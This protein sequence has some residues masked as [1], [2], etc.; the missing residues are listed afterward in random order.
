MFLKVFNFLLLFLAKMPFKLPYTL[1]L[2]GT[3]ALG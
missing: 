2:F 3:V 1:N